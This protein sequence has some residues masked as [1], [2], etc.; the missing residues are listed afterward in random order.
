LRRYRLRIGVDK[1]GRG[2]PMITGKDDDMR[3]VQDRMSGVLEQADPKRDLFQL[4]E[5]SERLGLIVDAV[6]KGLAD[7][8][9]FHA[10]HFNLCV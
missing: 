7:L 3:V 5:R 8:L 1:T 6:L 4:P 10:Y 9:R 2:Y